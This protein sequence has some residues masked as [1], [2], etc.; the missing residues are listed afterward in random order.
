MRHIFVN[1]AYDEKIDGTRAPLSSAESEKRSDTAQ[2][3][4]ADIASGESFESAAEK[5]TESYVAV[6][7][8]VNQMDISSGTANAPELGEA[9]KQMEIDEVRM[10]RSS[11]GLH[12][13][14]RVA[15]D[16]DNYNADET[17]VQNITS[18]LKN[19]LYPEV[20]ALYTPK[21]VT[22]GDIIGKYSMATAQL[23]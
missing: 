7:P 11:Y 5:Y 23:P 16:P 14:K 17:T 1:T 9:L 13:I 3:I 21:I 22:N 6:Y 20:I 2:K 4:Y 12:I 10:V 18:A 8:G 15:T 19:K